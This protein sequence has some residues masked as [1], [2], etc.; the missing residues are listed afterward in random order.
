[1]ASKSGG[2]Y[3][4][5]S[6]VTSNQRCPDCGAQLE[7][8][9]GRLHCPACDKDVVTRVRVLHECHKPC[10]ICENERLRA[11]LQGSDRACIN[12][13]NEAVRLLKDNERL[14]A[15]LSNLISVLTC[16]SSETERQREI[17]NGRAA[18]SGDFSKMEV[19]LCTH[20]GG[21]NRVPVSST[22]ETSARVETPDWRKLPF[23]P[24]LIPALRRAAK[25]G[26]LICGAAADALEAMTVPKITGA[27]EIEYPERGGLSYEGTSQPNDR[28][29]RATEE[30]DSDRPAAPVSE[31]RCQCGHSAR[32]HHIGTTDIKGPCG[33][34]SCMEWR[35]SAQETSAPRGKPCTCD[36][37]LGSSTSCRVDAGERLGDLWYC[38]KRAEKAS[39]DDVCRECGA[40][41]VADTCD[42]CGAE[43]AP[44]KP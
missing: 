13:S 3:M 18:L 42:K 30:T 43:N 27:R 38:R 33:T 23:H 2:T 11:E 24:S 29:N 14:R 25:R 41:L 1:M 15:V 10:M 6:S 16:N 7:H 44:G 32:A 31:E 5:D 9:T 21:E 36:N 4:S 19:I 12:A 26:D 20:C 40:E 39:A 34:C 8:F 22:H 37:C 35:S 17:R 28:G